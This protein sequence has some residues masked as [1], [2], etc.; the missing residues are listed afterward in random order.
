GGRGA[1]ELLD[2]G[3]EAALAGSV[4]R[5]AADGD[6]RA[7]GGEALGDGETDSAAGA[8][9]DGDLARERCCGRAVAGGDRA[10]RPCTAANRRART[11]GRSAASPR[12]ALVVTAEVSCL[13]PGSARHICSASRT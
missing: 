9:H 8:G 13:S 5:A 6:A 1:L 7:G 12:N 10:H 11:S 3:G 2:G 4:G